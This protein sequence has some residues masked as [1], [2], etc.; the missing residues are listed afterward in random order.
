MSE[1]SPNVGPNGLEAMFDYLQACRQLTCF[2]HQHDRVCMEVLSVLRT[3][4]LFDVR[5]FC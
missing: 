4:A 5:S 1:L 3:D 2:T